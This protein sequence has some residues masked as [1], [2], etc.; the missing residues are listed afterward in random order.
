MI[1]NLI[2]TSGYFEKL[3]PRGVVDVVHVKG[4][5]NVLFYIESNVRRFFDHGG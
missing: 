3:D 1:E 4:E 5:R 2:G